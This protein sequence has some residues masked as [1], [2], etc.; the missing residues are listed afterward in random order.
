MLPR[1]EFDAGLRVDRPQLAVARER[2]GGDD[3]R[4]ADGLAGAGLAAHERGR[5]PELERDRSAVGVDTPR[6]AVV[7]RDRAGLDAHERRRSGRDL[8]AGATHDRGPPASR[9]CV[10]FDDAHRTAG[11]G[12]DRGVVAAQQRE[13]CACGHAH[14]ELLPGGDLLDADDVRDDRDGGLSAP[15]SPLVLDGWRDRADPDRETQRVR[16]RQRGCARDRGDDCEYGDAHVGARAH[17]ERDRDDSGAT[18]VPP[19]DA[20]CSASGACRV[21]ELRVTGAPTRRAHRSPPTRQIVRF[22]VGLD[23]APVPPALAVDRPG[24]RREVRALMRP[25]SHCVHG[26]T[27]ALSDVADADGITLV[28]GRLSRHR[29]SQ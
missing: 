17:D 25:R 29:H 2:G 7:H 10:V 28:D 15:A 5:F 14:G 8:A 11:G 23:V 22:A 20:R 12:S 24:R 26:G 16:P 19:R 9:V 21:R 3:L 18:R 13:R 4:H 27:C 6:H 1:G